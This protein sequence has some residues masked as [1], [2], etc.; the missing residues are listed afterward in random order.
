MRIQIISTPRSGSTYLYTILTQALPDHVGYMEQRP[1]RYLDKLTPWRVEFEEKAKKQLAKMHDITN[2]MEENENWS[3]PNI[4]TK[5]HVDTARIP[6]GNFYK[7]LLTRKNLFKQ[8]LSL[9]IAT[10]TKNFFDPEIEP[11]GLSPKLFEDSFHRVIQYNKIAKTI[12]ADIKIYYEDLTFDPKKDL[13]TL[14]IETDMEI[15]PTLRNKSGNQT[16]LNMVQI[17]GLYN[18]LTRR[19][20]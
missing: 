14:G 1:I 13:K 17:K 19:M 20:V 7:I 3:L 9:A 2:Y 15:K 10:Q 11:I 6:Q 12:E 18:N 16:V 4:I 8:V 5:S